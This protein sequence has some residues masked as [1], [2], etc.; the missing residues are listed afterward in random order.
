MNVAQTYDDLADHYHLIFENWEFSVERQAAALSSILH[1]DCGLTTT[2]TILDCACGIGTQSLGL[3][4]LGFRVTGCDVSPR[5][6]E[7]ARLEA[8]RRNLNIQLSV[9]NMLN[10]T[11][12]ANSNFDVAICMDNSLPHLESAEHLL[13]AAEQIRSKLHPGG[14]LIASIRDYDHLAEERPIVQ[15]PS[16]Y[17]DEGRRRIVF[18][19]W[20]WVDARRYIFHLYITRELANGWQTFHTNGLY[21][22]IRRDELVA[23]LSQAGFKNPRWLSPA[24]SSFYQPIVLAEAV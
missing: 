21:R 2:S 5:A 17:L 23:I 3:A 10:L 19:V 4:K 20:D 9:A 8:L 22:A 15:R 18:Q 14:F 11:C 24:D 6:V 7:R 13:Q 12:L 1:R 16:F